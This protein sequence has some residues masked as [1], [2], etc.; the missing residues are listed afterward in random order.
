MVVVIDL[1]LLAQLFILLAEIICLMI[2]NKMQDSLAVTS[3][4]IHRLSISSVKSVEV[5][6]QN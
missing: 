5:A 3:S 1:F 4:S 6:S 2:A